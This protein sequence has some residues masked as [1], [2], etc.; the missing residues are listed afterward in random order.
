MDLPILM[1]HAVERGAPTGYAFAVSE[2]Q[3]VSQADILRRFGFQTISLGRLFDGLAGRAVLPRKPVV[4]TFDDGYRNVA[5]VAWPLMRE[6]GMTGTVFAVA[7][8]LGGTNVWDESAGHPRLE[9]MSAGVLREL[10]GDGWE[11]GS[12]GCRHR[13]LAKVGAAEAREE[14]VRSKALLEE[15][16]GTAV[17]FLAY[18]YGRHEEHT[19]ELVRAAGYRGAVSIFSPARS[20]T[21]DPFCMRRVLCHR[22]DTSLSFLLKLSPLYLRYVAWRD[23]RRARNGRK[24]E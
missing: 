7:D 13:D 6:R 23:L 17:D 18:P 22:G 16:A 5:E 15:A 21:A 4:L 2:K 24:A 3:F 11:I 8:H 10:A 19:G 12:H 9:L 14:V 1:Y 20:V